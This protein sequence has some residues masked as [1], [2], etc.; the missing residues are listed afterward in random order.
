MPASV[1]ANRAD[2]GKRHQHLGRHQQLALWEAVG[3]QAAPG[4]EKQDRQELQ[5]GGEPDGDAAAGQA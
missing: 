5:R 4:A 2:G 1:T 3:E